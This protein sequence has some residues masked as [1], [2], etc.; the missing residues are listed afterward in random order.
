MKKLWKFQ[1]CTLLIFCNSF[2]AK[3][4]VALDWVHHIGS[5][6]EDLGYS[7]AIDGDGNVYTTGYF[8]GT[9]DFDPGP[10]TFNM[11]AQA[12]NDAFIT[13][14]DADGNLV[15]A[16]QVRGSSNGYGRGIAVDDL[17]NVYITGVFGGTIDV[18][19]GPGTITFTASNWEGYILK[20]NANGDYVWAHKIGGPEAD[21][22]TAVKIDNEGNIF[23]TGL[24]NGTVDF[25]PGTEV[26]QLTTVGSGDV[27]IL[28]FSS[29]GD[30]LWVKQIG[31][32]GYD[33]PHSLAIDPLNNIFISGLF[34]GTADFDPGPGTYNLST[35]GNNDNFVCKLDANGGFI[36][37]KAFGG[38]WYDFG[39]AMAVDGIGNVYITGYFG[40]GDF[41]PGP[42]VYNM[43][44]VGGYDSFILKLDSNGNFIWAKQ[45]GGTYSEYSYGID[46]DTEGNIFMTGKYYIDSDLDP[47]P[48]TYTL[49]SAGYFDVFILSLDTN[50]NFLWAKGFGGTTEDSGHAIKTDLS[51]NVY[52]SGVFRGT[53]DFDPGAGKMELTSLG[54]GDYFLQK[55]KPCTNTFHSITETAC[56]SYTAP[57][58]EIYTTSGIKT[59]VIPNLAGCDSTITI[60]LTINYSTT[61]SITETAC[62]SYTAP[63][64]EIYT[65]SGIKTAVIPNLAGCDS[66]ISIDLTINHS[67]TASITETACDSYTAP[68]GE[69]YT[70]SGIKTA[71]IPNLAGCDS[72]IT[73]DLTINYST[74]ASI[75]ETACDSYTAPDGE[76][77]TTSGI[78]TAV[79]PNLAGCDSTITIDLTINHSTMASITE[80]ACDS[81][82]APDG[83]IYTTSGIKTAVIPNLAGCDSTITIDLTINYSTAAS[84]TETACDSYTAPDG[85]VYT[86]SGIKTAVIPNLAGCDSTI[87]IDLTINH[88]TTASITET[89]C[90]SYTA[91]DGEVYT[92]SGIKT[93]VI[94][95]L[96]RCDSTIIIDLSIINIDATVIADNFTI[97]AN[98]AGA[99]YQWLDCNDNYSEL[100][101]EINQ[102][103]TAFSNGNYAVIVTQGACSDTSECVPIV[104]VKVVENSSE[105]SIILYPN[106]TEGLFYIDLGK[107]SGQVHVIINDLQGHIIS[108]QLFMNEKILSLNIDVPAG[109]Y[110]LTINS[111]EIRATIKLI[112]Y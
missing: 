7:I 15:W 19:P 59:A 99:E 105:Q 45:F 3:S 41:D 97:T 48:G 56:D 77:Y 54:L 80:T 83:E 82:T 13:K 92:T 47:G 6:G 110:F 37:A 104:G 24:F 42:E 89:A 32:G 26:Y 75:T 4:Q 102:G 81:Y 108:R 31:S 53:A 86:T 107:S 90:D 95:N 16:K 52:T 17:G 73:I 98:T 38:T 103:Y 43:S 68:D 58:G 44:S 60:D 8:S 69:V 64:G 76:I 112:K 46:V 10:G 5:G 51:G 49:T 109:I 9:A 40:S 35:A 70:T 36:W 27:Y 96:A 20:L 18:D 91:P 55:L 57:D 33:S 28:K 74:A 93:A 88:S 14:L 101:G 94:P 1:L 39:Q 30:F 25:D 71:V 67:T 22:G 34:E 111:G 100:E 11:T 87:T 78:K 21:G 106:P 2:M 85:E 50:G 72:T 29:D 63:D 84:I 79:I 66:V 62:D 12:Y 23:V 61:A 65:T